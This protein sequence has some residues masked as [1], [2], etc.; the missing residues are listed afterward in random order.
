MRSNV[1]SHHHRS[2]QSNNFHRS[3]NKKQFR[4]GKENRK[5]LSHPPS[6]TPQQGCPL[7]VPLGIPD[8]PKRFLR[9]LIAS[10]IDAYTA[11]PSTHVDPPFFFSSSSHLIHVESC[12][13]H[14][15]P[16]HNHKDRLLSRLSSSH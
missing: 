13:A 14:T 3:E 10:Q 4:K 6:A 7:V 15:E 2:P 12:M 8:Y 1:I 5:C 11:A 9:C 16:F